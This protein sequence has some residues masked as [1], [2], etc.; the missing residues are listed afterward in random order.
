MTAGEELQ[1][2]GLAVGRIVS[3]DEHPGARAPSFRLT[4]ELARGQRRQAALPTA[5]YDKDELLDRQVL[6]APDGEGMLVLA[7]QSHAK[8]LVLLVP[9]RQVEDGSAVA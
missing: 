5:L 9:E 2:L 6:C 4:L 7:V 3:V 1:R 8:G